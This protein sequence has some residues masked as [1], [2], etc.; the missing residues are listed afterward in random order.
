MGKAICCR[1]HRSSIR[2]DPTA[3]LRSRARRPGQSRVRP[4]ASAC[5]LPLSNY[6]A[7]PTCSYLVGEVFF[8]NAAVPEDTVE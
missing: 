1:V 8:Q 7:V 4:R 6:G 5:A 2:R 3:A